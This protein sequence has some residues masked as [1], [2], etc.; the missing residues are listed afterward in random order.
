MVYFEK[1]LYDGIVVLSFTKDNLTYRFPD[2]RK[3][4]HAKIHWTRVKNIDHPVQYVNV[5][6]KRIF[7]FKK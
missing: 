7:A 5:N 4:Y 2:G 6:G 1:G 3:H